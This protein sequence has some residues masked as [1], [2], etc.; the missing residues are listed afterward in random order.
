MPVNHKTEI[1]IAAVGVVVSIVGIVLYKRGQDTSNATAQAQADALAQEQQQL[2]QYL[3]A[4]PNYSDASGS[5]GSAPAAS[6]TFDPTAGGLLSSSAATTAPTGNANDAATSAAIA[7]GWTFNPQTGVWAPPITVTPTSTTPTAGTSNPSGPL[8]SQPTPSGPLSF[9]P[10]A[11]VTNPAGTGSV[12]SG[13]TRPTPL[14]G[15]EPVT[16]EPVTATGP[17]GIGVS[18]PL[19]VGSTFTPFGGTPAPVAAP[20]KTNTVTPIPVHRQI[21]AGL[22]GSK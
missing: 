19:P 6:T 10:F 7:E 2:S 11:P 4:Q 1:I 8:A 20:P 21:L 9:T 17:V 14:I 3:E 13:S 15:A 16:T 12:T 5:G 18:N 22:V